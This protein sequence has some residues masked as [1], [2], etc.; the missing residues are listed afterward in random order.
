MKVSV[1][2]ALS[3]NPP[4]SSIR[5]LPVLANGRR[6]VAPTADLELMVS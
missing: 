1:T 2:T 3:I 4:V 5:L 6:L